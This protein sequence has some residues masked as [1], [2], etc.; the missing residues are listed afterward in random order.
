MN[1][2]E[3][4]KY[5]FLAGVAYAFFRQL[6]KD[7]N[8]IGIAMRQEKARAERRW[9]FEVADRIEDAITEEMRTR[10]AARV[11]HDAYRDS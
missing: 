8:G 6:R 9:K 11:R 3:L 5:A 7:V 10:L 2:T 1:G 4:L